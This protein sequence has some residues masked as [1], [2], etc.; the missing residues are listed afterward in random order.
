MGNELREAPRLVEPP[1]RLDR[2]VSQAVWEFAKEHSG[3]EAHIRYH[4]EPIWVLRKEEDG[5]VKRI[6]LAF[7]DFPDGYALYVTPDR[8]DLTEEDRRKFRLDGQRVIPY[9]EAYESKEVKRVLSE[10]VA[11]SIR[12]QA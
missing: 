10:I 7:F 2:A 9:K 5:K 8:S 6:Q 12:Y 4:D 1:A 3:W 11:F